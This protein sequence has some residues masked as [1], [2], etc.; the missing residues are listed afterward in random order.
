M[1]HA[2]YGV[3]RTTRATALVVSLS[4]V[5]PLLAGCGGNKD[6]GANLPPIDASASGGNVQQQQQPRQGMSTGK[7]VA[8]LAGAAAVYYLWKRNQDKRD[9]SNRQYYL[10]K[11]GRVYYRDENKRAV[12]VTPPRQPIEVPMDEIERYPDVRQFRGYDNSTQ[13]YGDLSHLYR[14]E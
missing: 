1:T 5:A 3:R 13:G 4:L 14:G 8:L 12:W 7:K 11:N 6:S 2:T 10:S 9:N